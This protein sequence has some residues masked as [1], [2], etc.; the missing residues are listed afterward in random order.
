MKLLLAL[1]LVATMLQHQEPPAGWLCGNTAK[2]PADHQCKCERTCAWN[3]ETRQVEEK[4]DVHCK[5]FCWRSH[6]AC[7]SEC[8]SH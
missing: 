5:V 7:L 3:P 2:T 6:C 4:E 1:A 8:D